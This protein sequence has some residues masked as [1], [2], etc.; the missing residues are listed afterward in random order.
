VAGVHLNSLVT[1]PSD[2]P[3]DLRDLSAADEAR[4]A[5]SARF[6]RDLSG[7]MKIQSTRPNT[8]AYGLN[9]SPIGLLSWIV[10]KFKDWT[11]APKAPED[12]VSRDRI[13]DIV[14]IYW[15][16]GTA[17]SAAQM[18]FEV[19][20]LLPIARATG[21]YD[22]IDVPL[23]IAVFPHAP[24][25]PIRRFVERDFPTLAH[26]SEFDRGGNFAALEQPDLFVGD[27]RSFGRL[28]QA[29]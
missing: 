4:M 13:L 25:I 19:A 12:A 7:S 2:D 23:G 16:S 9:D 3:A 15:F 8:V 24:F 11:D 27:V 5:H 10:E 1:T 29:G 28:V 17:G 21:R 14:S 22:P 20:G 6:V 18:Y 26:W